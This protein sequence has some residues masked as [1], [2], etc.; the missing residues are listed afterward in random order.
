MF[1]NIRFVWIWE[2]SNQRSF[3]PKELCLLNK[4]QKMNYGALDTSQSCLA[5]WDGDYKNFPPDS[6]RFIEQEIYIL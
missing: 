2:A 6:D 1:P 3:L 4:E 5:K